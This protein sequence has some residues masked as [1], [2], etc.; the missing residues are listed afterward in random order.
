MTSVL[1]LTQGIELD[2]KPSTELHLAIEGISIKAIQDC[3][4]WL[5]EA[6]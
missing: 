5:K 1:T 2:I 3:Q 4:S 6:N